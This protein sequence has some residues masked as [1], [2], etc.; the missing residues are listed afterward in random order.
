MS[1]PSLKPFISVAPFVP[2]VGR[3]CKPKAWLPFSNSSSQGDGLFVIYLPRDIAFFK[4]TYEI[5][6]L[7]HGTCSVENSFI[8]LMS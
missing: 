8:E 2:P 5:M 4:Y 1:F 6:V 7:V 3:P